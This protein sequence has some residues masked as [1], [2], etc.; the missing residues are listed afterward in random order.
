ML[1]RLQRG[2]TGLGVILANLSALHPLLEKTISLRSTLR[3]DGKR[4]GYSDPKSSDNY[5]ELGERSR[6]VPTRAPA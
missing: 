2:R 5:L 6:S 3:S 4:S 1:C